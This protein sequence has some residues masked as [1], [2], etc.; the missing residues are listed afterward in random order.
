[1]RMQDNKRRKGFTLIELMIVVGIVAILATLAWPS[2]QRQI[3]ANKRKDAIKALTTASNDMEK[4]RTDK[5]SYTN[6]GTVFNAAS[7]EGRY[8][9]TVQIAANGD[10]YTLTATQNAKDDKDCTTLTL[11]NLGQKNS[12]G[13][14]TNP[15]QCWGD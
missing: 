6:C 15:H 2:F 10:A 4:C 8:T 5:G 13:N 9:I 14:Y 7:P 12:T 11:N 1:M 3:D